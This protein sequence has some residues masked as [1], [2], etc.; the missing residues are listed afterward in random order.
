MNSIPR[1]NIEHWAVLRAVIEHGSFAQ[2]AAKLHRSQSA[3]SYAI[4]R[5]QDA[6]GIPLLEAHGRRAV[7]TPA[8]RMFLE[9]AMPLV[10]DLVRLEE[11]VKIHASGGITSLSLAVDSLFPRARLFYALRQFADQFPKVDVSL[12]ETVRQTVGPRLAFDLAIVVQE[13]SEPMLDP[14]CDIL[15]HAVAHRDHPLSVA[16]NLISSSTLARFTRADIQSQEPHVKGEGRYEA[17]RTWRVNTIE[18]AVEAVRCGLCFAWLPVHLIAADIDSGLLRRLPLEEGA[19]R[20]VTLALC[21]GQRYLDSDDPA[22]HALSGLL[23]S[24]KRLP[25]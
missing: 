19:T 9:E 18:S 16:G 8:G 21:R 23:R 15:L 10:D 13:T 3:V 14:V 4:A 17:V 24:G 1:S 6:V 12:D 5:L 25:A 22:I 7:L 11:R 2:A 20:Q